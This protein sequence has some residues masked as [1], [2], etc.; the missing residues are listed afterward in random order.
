MQ[1]TILNANA[2]EFPAGKVS[3][4]SKV[5]ITLPELQLRVLLTSSVPQDFI[6]RCLSHRAEQRP[7]ILTIFEDDYFRRR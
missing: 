5:G 3:E 1:K 6:R 2:V 7:D 4:E